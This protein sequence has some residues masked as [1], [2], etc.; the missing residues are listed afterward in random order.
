MPVAP[1]NP[2][3]LR[4]V[5]GDDR[6]AAVQRAADAAREILGGRIVVH[7]N[8]TA[9]GGGVAE[10]LPTL[11]GYAGGLGIDTRWVVLGGEPEFFRITKRLHNHLHGYPGDSGTLD[12]RERVVYERL[13][14]DAGRDLLAVLG[15][16]DIAVLHDPQ[17]LGLAPLLRERGIRTVWRCHIGVD[18]GNDVTRRGWRFLQPYLA[19]VDGFAFSRKT[20]R[21]DVISTE[22]THIITPT[23]DPLSTKNRPLSAADG[24]AILAHAGLLQGGTGSTPTYRRRDGSVGRVRRRAEVVQAGPPPPPDRP[25]VVQVSRWDRLTSILGTAVGGE[26]GVL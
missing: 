21:H 11:L 22:R 9:A 18:R 26:A 12:D 13:L 7:V 6:L 3:D 16:D 17:T 1:L 23:L 8:A 24:R 19:A 25:L 2:A 14:A 15:P 20:F 4:G 10:M 5:I